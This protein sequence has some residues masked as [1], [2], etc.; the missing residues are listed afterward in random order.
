MKFCK[1]CAHY[2]PGETPRSGHCQKAHYVS[3]EDGTVQL[4]TAASFRLNVCGP[5]KAKFFE[6]ANPIER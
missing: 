2:V 3:T 5:T 4:H 1:D 6:P